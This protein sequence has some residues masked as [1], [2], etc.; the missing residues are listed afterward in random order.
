MKNAERYRL[1][2]LRFHSSPKRQV[3]GRA[4]ESLYRV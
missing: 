1:R 3:G 2:A 4:A